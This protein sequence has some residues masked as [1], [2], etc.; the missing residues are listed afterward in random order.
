MVHPALNYTLPWPGRTTVIGF[1]R[2]PPSVT[3]TT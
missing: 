2:T 3:T 1:L